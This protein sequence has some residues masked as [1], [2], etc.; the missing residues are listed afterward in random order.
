MSVSD[1]PC[2]HAGL[3]VVAEDGVV[4]SAR[5]HG[6][7]DA[8]FRLLLSHGCGFAADA[9]FPFWSEFADRYEVVVYDM[10]SHGR[11]GAG[12]L[13]S[14]NVPTLVADSQAMLDSVQERFGA[15]PTIGVFHSLSAVVGLLH[16]AREPGFAALVLFDPPIQP[17]DGTPGDIEAIGQHMAR[18]AR[19]RRDRFDNP[20]QLARGLARSPAFERVPE[21]ARAA[22][23]AALLREDADGWRLR[24]P[25]EH[26]A[27][28][29]EWVFG[30]TMH[31]P[32]V[33]GSLPIPVKI[34]G[35][36]PTVTFSFLP[37]VDLSDL[38]AVSYDFVPECT[39]FLQIENPSVTAAL[40]ID[41]LK[42]HALA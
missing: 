40:T 23:A 10:R 25:P 39:H 29:F 13:T 21:A 3:D 32:Q 33:I 27:R 22:L 5:Q 2:A 41:F 1:V 34:I 19:G 16:A 11:S 18:A 35:A 24:C 42:S 30:F 36:D 4:L 6:N 8:P 9:Y 31:L 38:A 26:E 17:T 14:L 7:V 28:L 12:L 15:K 37:T 20:D